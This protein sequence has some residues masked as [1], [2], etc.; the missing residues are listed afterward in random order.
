MHTGYINGYY[1]KPWQDEPVHTKKKKNKL[2]YIVW[3]FE[4]AGIILLCMA[5]MYQVMDW[6]LFFIKNINW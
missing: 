2:S 6:L 5:G 3:S 4:A 1:V